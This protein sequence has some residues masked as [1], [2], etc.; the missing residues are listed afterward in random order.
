MARLN[1]VILGLLRLRPMTGYELKKNIEASVGQFWTA[2]Y[3]G[4]Y[5][6]LGRL[7]ADG[8][9]EQLAERDGK[10]YAV[11]EKGRQAFTQWLRA[12]SATATIKDEFLLR[13]FFCSDAELVA[14][15]PAI[16]R[17]VADDADRIERLRALPS[18]ATSMTRGQ[19]L[20]LALGTRQLEIEQCLLVELQAELIGL[21]GARGDAS[22][23]E[24]GRP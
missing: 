22:T 7:S 6:A 19:A 21:P 5:P 9:I 1:P 13:L 23:R 16:G 14:L 4:L 2:S 17:R 11:T 8:Q 18:Q 20:C 10:V 12:A 15:L 3:G 24:G